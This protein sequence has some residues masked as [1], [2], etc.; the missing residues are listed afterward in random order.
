M[1]GDVRT[2]RRFLPGLLIVVALST[3]NNVPISRAFASYTRGPKSD[4]NAGAIPADIAS[5]M[6]SAQAMMDGKHPDQLATISTQ[7]AQIAKTWAET[8]KGDWKVGAMA[9]PHAAGTARQYLAIFHRWHLCEADGDHV[10]KIVRSPAGAES[11]WKIGAEIPET[12]TDGFRIR[13][14]N[15]VV[16]TKLVDKSISISD[17]VDLE[18]NGSSENGFGLLRLSDD[19]T[20]TSLQ[21]V[22]PNQSNTKVEYHQVGGIVSFVP[23]ADKKFTLKMSYS[24]VVDHPDGDFLKPDEITLSAYW[25]PV[26]A[27][28]PATAT[29]TASAAPGFTAIAQGELVA[30]NPGQDGSKTYTY[31]NDMAVSYF[32]LD[33]GRYT[34]T[35]RKVND[36]TLSVYL[37]DPSSSLA[38]TCLDVTEKSLKYYETNFGAFPY[39]IYGLVQTRGVAEMALE[40]YSFATFG[41][42][43][44]P[45][46]IPHELSHTWWGGRIPC[47]Y[48][49]S[50][51]NEAFADYSDNLFHRANDPPKNRDAASILR[52]RK[53]V[54]HAFDAMPVMQA[55]DTDNSE[56]ITVGYYKG[57][58]VLRVLEEEIGK[59]IMLKCMAAF[60]MNHPNG[61]AGEWAEFEQVVNQ[62][63]KQDYSW[64]FEQWLERPGVPNIRFENVDVGSTGSGKVIHLDIIQ[65]GNPYRLNL[66][67]AIKLSN[68]A[69]LTS[70]QKIEGPRT[71]IDI[72]ISAGTPLKITLD[73]SGLVPLAPPAGADLDQPFTEHGL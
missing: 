11:N 31:R 9:P 56:Q 61:E 70:H 23:P 71:H 29:V 45:D 26:I 37:L 16:S 22:N 52:E 54:A 73:P 13:N 69:T 65:A 68:G 36:K 27:R 66:E 1:F 6:R 39:T 24:G 32:S 12:E 72:P 40:A 63:T 17:T 57:S 8:T 14:H 25:Y 2:K 18:Q 28:L 48:T 67:C 35:R 30:T 44:L 49:R 33:I 51:W 15:L 41:P 50:M 46:L 59:P 62:I 47:T 58:Q 10:Y 19:Y 21:L 38:K 34:I 20:V 4:A 60:L 3:A 64:F 42:H 53:Q 55:F 5:L 7:D 43:C